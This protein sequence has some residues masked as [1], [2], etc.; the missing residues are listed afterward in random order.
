MSRQVQGQFV[1][2]RKTGEVKH[3]FFDAMHGS[4][5]KGASNL[6]P[7][8]SCDFLGTPSAEPHLRT[9]SCIAS[10]EKLGFAGECSFSE[11]KNKCSTSPAINYLGSARTGCLSERC[12]GLLQQGRVT[13]S[14]SRE[15]VWTGLLRRIV[16][17]NESS[18]SAPINSLSLPIPSR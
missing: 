4:T 17:F 1:F 12:T 8:K 5:V 2:T 9:A 7:K 6:H 3:L 15:W 14:P 16:S 18:F 13:P 11:S 10:V